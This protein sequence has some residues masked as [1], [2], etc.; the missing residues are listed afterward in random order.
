MTAQL[1]DAQEP[2]GMESSHSEGVRWTMVQP[3]PLFMSIVYARALLADFAND[4]GEVLQPAAM[5]TR[6]REM[7][8]TC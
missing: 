4:K 1:L 7:F 3:G 2:P 5:H 8:L 6:S